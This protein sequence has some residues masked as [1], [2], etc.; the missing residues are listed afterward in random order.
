[1]GGPSH[2]S[3][4]MLLLLL[5]ETKTVFGS[6]LGWFMES[7]HYA[8]PVLVHVP[9]SSQIMVSCCSYCGLACAHL[10]YAGAKSR[11]Q[12][13]GNFHLLDCRTTGSTASAAQ[14]TKP[15][16]TEGSGS[17]QVWRK[18]ME[19]GQAT[20]AVSSVE[21]SGRSTSH[22]LFFAPFNRRRVRDEGPCATATYGAASASA[23]SSCRSGSG[24]ELN[25]RGREGAGQRQPG[26][27]TRRNPS[28]DSQQARDS[29]VQESGAGA[30]RPPPN[31]PLTSIPTTTGRQRQ[32]WPSS[33]YVLCRLRRHACRICHSAA[34]TAQPGCTSARG[35]ASP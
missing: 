14:P 20:D 4:K 8:S 34:L 27:R 10:L 18:R 22:L 6:W 9:Q 16:M 7:R 17:A 24:G 19:T 3:G 13:P 15:V 30:A 21:C 5:R 33:E 12:T 31:R 2:A 28:G 25:E 35:C 11:V 1:M 32:A 23:T 29:S 26:G